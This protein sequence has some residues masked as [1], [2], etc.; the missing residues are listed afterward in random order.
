MF[1][2]EAEIDDILKCEKCKN[3]FDE[4]RSLPCGSLVC[5]ACL[6]TLLRLIGQN[7]SSFKCTLCQATHKNGEFPENKSIKKLLGKSAIQVYRS[8]LVE[9]FQ[10]NLK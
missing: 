10:S 6:D 5:N 1:F 9:K 7:D 2:Q 4:P 3:K 8:D